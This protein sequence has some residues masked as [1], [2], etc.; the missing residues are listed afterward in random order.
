MRGKAGLQLVYA[1]S[2]RITP[3]Y[4]GKSGFKAVG[5]R[6]DEDHPRICGEK[7]VCLHGVQDRSGSPPHMR[8]KGLEI[9]VLCSADRITPAYAGK[10]TVQSGEVW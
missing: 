3:A 1:Q 9:L 10:S 6:F 2:L 8:G 7:A 5:G 4:A